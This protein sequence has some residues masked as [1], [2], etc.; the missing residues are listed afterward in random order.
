[1]RNNFKKFIGYSVLGLALYLT[2]VKENSYVFGKYLVGANFAE[3]RYFIEK[4]FEGT[5][6]FYININP[7]DFDR[8]RIEEGDTLILEEIVSKNIFNTETKKELRIKVQR[9]PKKYF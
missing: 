1:M 3:N 9:N 7:A 6:L 8:E 5:P 2:P 4:T